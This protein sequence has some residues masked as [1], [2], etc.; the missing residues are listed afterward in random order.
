[1]PIRQEAYVRQT[2]LKEEEGRFVKILEAAPSVEHL[3]S[4]FGTCLL[5]RGCQYFLDV[6]GVEPDP[7]KHSQR[8]YAEIENHLLRTGERPTVYAHVTRYDDTG[9]Y[10]I[11]YWFLYLF[12]YRLNEHESDWEQITLRLDEDKQPVDAFYSQHNGGVVRP[13][14][15]VEKDGEHPVDYPALGSHAN[16]FTPGPHPV[17][18]V[19]KRLIAGITPCFRGRKVIVDVSDGQGKTLTPA[20]YT[21]ASLAGPVFVG[22]YGSGNYVVLTRRPDA[23]RR[24]AHAAD[25]GRPAR[26]VSLTGERRRVED[27]VDLPEHL[28]AAL[29]AALVVAA[30]RVLEHV[31]RGTCSQ[32]VH[33]RGAPV[34]A[35]REERGEVV[36]RDER[37]R[38]RDGVAVA[39]RRS[40]G[41]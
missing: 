33:G 3:I 27:G 39:A 6:R 31:R 13:W 15:T 9:E 25:L 34:V 36:V 17:Q 41:G 2:Q 4:E 5:S 16:Y 29:E 20:D 40:P 8:A 38:D 37:P 12:N 21:L 18:I 35:L 28:L 22:S 1:M 11:Q 30:E 10:A 19:C 7:P 14:S 23:P 32:Y 24:P 26:P